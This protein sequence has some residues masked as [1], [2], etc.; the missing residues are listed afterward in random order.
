MLKTFEECQQK[1]FLKYIQKL[2]LVQPQILFESGKKIHALA[3]YYLKM[4]NVEKMEK[5]LNINEK[6]IWENLKSNK[7]FSLQAVNTEYSLSCK[8]DKYWVGGRLD[9]LMKEENNFFILDYKTGNIPKDAQWDFQT[10]IYLLCTDKLL[11]EKGGYNKLRFIY[12][13][14]K[15]NIEK[16]ILFDE[17]LKKQ[18]EE[19][20]LLSCEKIKM[21][22]NSNYFEKNNKTC[23]NCEYFKICEL[24]GGKIANLIPQ[25][26]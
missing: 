26:C 6:L 19:K 1:F 24:D 15:N 13:G 12:L 14:L 17:G 9:A 5:T 2:I 18:Y 20:I 25:S 21:A 3:N 8:V 11:N 22:M 16:E 4:E 10:I 23:K 7:Y